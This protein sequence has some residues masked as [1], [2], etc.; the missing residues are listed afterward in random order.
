MVGGLV[1]VWTVAACTEQKLRNRQFGKLRELWVIRRVVSMTPLMAYA[2][3]W[4]MPI[5]RVSGLF[6]AGYFGVSAA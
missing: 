5:K 3:V 2:K 6:R 4:V 1:P